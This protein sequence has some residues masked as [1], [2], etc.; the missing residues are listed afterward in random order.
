[1]IDLHGMCLIYNNSEKRFTHKHKLN[2]FSFLFF[3][4]KTFH[5]LTEKDIQLFNSK[6]N[7][8]NNILISNL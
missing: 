4:E 6:E 1:M 5:S 7:Y 8:F 3:I 2:V